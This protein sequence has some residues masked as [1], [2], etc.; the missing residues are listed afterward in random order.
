MK[1][2][3]LFAAALLAAPV[4]LGAPVR[5]STNGMT[6]TGAA[7][8]TTPPAYPFSVGESFAYSAKLGVLSLGSASLA[9]TGT[10]TVRG[11]EFFPFPFSPP[12]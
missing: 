7:R 12:R 6:I 8:T 11:A 1:H 3:S 2:A 4:L 9:V 5:T 10:D